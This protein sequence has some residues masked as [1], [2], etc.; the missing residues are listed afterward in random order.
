[1]D[2]WPVIHAE[3]KSLAGDLRPLTD[4]QW[5]TASLCDGGRFVTCSRT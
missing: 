5:D 1:M 2:I 3:R 4:E